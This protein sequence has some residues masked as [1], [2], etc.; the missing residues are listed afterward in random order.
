M[1]E[2]GYSLVLALRFVLWFI[3]VTSE[4]FVSLIM[5]KDQEGAGVSYPNLPYAI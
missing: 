3:L 1:R 4:L 5:K 2:I